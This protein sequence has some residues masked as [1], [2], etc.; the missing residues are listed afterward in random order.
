M[1][2]V[3]PTRSRRGAALIAVLALIVL[4]AALVTVFLV[5]TAVERSASAS[6]DA[7]AG[8]RL[9]AETTVNLTQA[10]I[11]E[12]TSGTNG[13][14]W[15]SQPGAIRTFDSSGA[16]SRIYRLYSGTEIATSGTS[17]S[18]LAGDI[19][20]ANWANEP[21]VWVDLNKPVTVSGVS[22][23]NYLVFPILD[24]RDP[25]SP[26]DLT[27]PNVLTSLEGFSISGAPGS[28]DLQP[29]PMPVRWLYVL[30]DG[31]IV[32]PAVSGSNVVVA[33]ASGT[34]PI[35]GRIAFWADDETA[36]VNINTA[37][38]SFAN[39]S[40]TNIPG[41]W[42]TPRFRIFEERM[43]FSE[44]QPVKGEYQ[45]YPGHPAT[46]DLSR[47]LTALGV[48][49][50]GYPY[51]FSATASP[52]S[53]NTSGLFSLLP[54]YTDS[55][56]SQGGTKNTTKTN[57]VPVINDGVPKQ[58]RLYPSV[59]EMLFRQ[60]RANAGLTRQQ[61]EV[62]K[63]FL[64]AQS[65][66]P[67]TTLF[68]TPRIPMWPVNATPG[69]TTRTALDN[70]M[71][72][73]AT[74]GT[75]AN[76]HTYVLQRKNANSTTED[77]ASI[78][79]N[80]NLFSY[81]KNLSTREIPGFGGNV[82]A[83]YPYVRIASGSLPASNEMDQILTEMVDYIRCTNLWDRG[84]TAPNF[85]RFSI[86][87]PN[88]T[89]YNFRGSALPLKIED[90][91]VA[92]S[93][94]GRSQ[95]I[96]E[97]GIL[98]ICTADGNSPLGPYQPP[99]TVGSGTV[100]P[101][102]GS[103]NDPLYVS[104]LPV[105]QFLRDDTGPTGNIV[106]LNA[107]RAPVT[108]TPATIPAGAT[109]FP[110]N[111]TL[112]TTGAHGGP[113]AA[114]A[115][116]QRKLQAML[117][118]EVAS[119]MMGFHSLDLSGSPPFKLNV[120]GIE[121]VTIDGQN[122][123]PNRTS[124][125]D[126]KTDN[127]NG[128]GLLDKFPPRVSEQETGGL[129]GFRYLTRGRFNA[130]SGKEF[131]PGQTSQPVEGQPYRYVSNP[132]TVSGTNMSLGGGF[133]VELHVPE[134][135]NA[136][137][138]YQGIDVRFPTAP[139]LPV[140]DLMKS[141]LAKAPTVAASETP[142]YAADWWGFDMR[143]RLGT[144][145]IANASD[146]N[147]GNMTNFP[148]IRRGAVIRADAPLPTSAGW[149]WAYNYVATVEQPNFSN[150][151]DAAKFAGSDVVRTLVAKDGDYRLVAA[152]SNMT[153]DASATSPFAKGPGYDDGVKLGNLFKD[154]YSALA[155]AGVD[156]QGKLVSGA[157]YGWHFAPKV[158]STMNPAKQVTW[159]WDNGLPAEPDGAYA[160]KA[161]E[162]NI[163]VSSASPYYNRE[164][165]SLTNMPSYFTANRIVNSPVMFGSLPTGVVEGVSWRTL[166]FRPSPSA[167]R[168]FDSAGPKDH[169]FLD[170]FW[171]P[172]VEPY[173]ISEPFSTAGK[174][175]MNYQ[176][177]PFTY[178]ERSTGIRAV[179]SSELIARV[180]KA[181]AA[182]QGTSWYQTIYKPSNSVY[183]PGSSV[184][185]AGGTTLARLP[186]DLNETLKQFETKF[187]GTTATAEPRDI[188]KSAS[189]ICDIYLVPK[190]YT[191]P[192]FET[193]WY[194]DDFALVGDNVRERPYGNIYPRLTTKSNT[195]TVHY[196]V[197]T[198]KN[199][200]SANPQIWTEGRGQITGE[201]RGSTTLER[202]LD[203]SDPKIPDYAANPNAESLDTFYQW[204]VISNSTF[205]P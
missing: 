6:Y 183:G 34:N 109:P 69:L 196:T 132:F 161:D 115:P 27:K 61:L 186:I 15:A 64:T 76:A 37:A 96:S 134:P 9:L 50:S 95:T 146:T 105:P 162:G 106:G 173:A 83:K 187:S 20:P 38:G 172:V 4:L 191:W 91:G 72:F 36:K 168:P 84:T 184:V 58:D 68:G 88:V 47:I 31:Q 16:L 185:S 26:G 42:D 114:L 57:P 180:P 155:T 158:P 32:T 202:F 193:A 154:H 149:K 179:L 46:T 147:L 71:A 142:D 19:P 45:R 52:P 144:G 40:G 192:S 112:T 163:Y 143:I 24:P 49:L 97:I 116:G 177:V 23:S 160:N 39:W 54:R 135:N 108:G 86:N 2:S 80:Q 104:N 21:S 189:E 118:F 176:I 5:R 130:W 204:R 102:R 119:P 120:T 77:Y 153:A 43:L 7:A 8:T 159:D 205:A 93:G 145:P 35:T 103:A 200:P 78:P 203:P 111:P 174:V 182:R 92:T 75:G 65:R 55:K 124:I 82:R 148:R 181:A 137:S 167:N 126:S 28:T 157:D 165:E 12:A 175:N 81:L 100:S 117:L 62:G 190:G 169:L 197:Q 56:S 128:N 121:G 164:S 125:G 41:T 74:T 17:G 60:N 66:A 188:F 110:A 127:I 131:V 138:I 156:H 79:R 195:F 136:S 122:P 29:A 89:G 151:T 14:A 18:V 98:I 123:F 3:W 129:L 107:D 94:F 10:T 141:G 133:R 30:R 150:Q 201:L 170:W 53:T 199:P 152:Q 113:L 73:C 25:Q 101:V 22:G 33:G 99:V 90:N 194:G 51:T 198:L 13:T 11:N 178:I 1:K 67:E 140:P 48:P 70:L 63:F 171:M 139:N 166:L 87:P 85:T 44:N 59:G